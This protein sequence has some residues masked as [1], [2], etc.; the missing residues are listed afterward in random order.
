M[1]FYVVSGELAVLIYDSMII[2]TCDE[3]V[4]DIGLYFLQGLHI[5]YNV[6]LWLKKMRVKRYIVL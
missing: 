6:F 2:N 1:N 5:I 4:R 3:S